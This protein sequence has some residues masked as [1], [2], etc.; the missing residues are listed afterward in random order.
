MHDQQSITQ[1]TGAEFTALTDSLT[2]EER[3][4]ALAYLWGAHPALL[5]DALNWAAHKRQHREAGATRRLS[6][7]EI[8]PPA[9]VQMAEFAEIVSGRNPY[10]HPRAVITDSERTCQQANPASGAWCHLP[11]P[12]TE[13]RDT[14]G[15]TWTLPAVTA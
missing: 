9:S 3:D 15:E 5:A 11:A 2:A 14:D 6:P 7:P 4:D 8:V 1:M 10:E 12:H 13:H